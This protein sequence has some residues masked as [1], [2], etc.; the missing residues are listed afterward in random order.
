M[1]EEHGQ[2]KRRRIL[3]PDIAGSNLKLWLRSDL[4]I[5][6]VADPV[7]AAWT[8]AAGWSAAGGGVYSHAGGADNLSQAILV[9]GNAYRVTYT[10]SGV[11]GGTIQP[12]AGT[13]AG[14]SR[15]ADGTYTEVL[16]CAGN[17]SMIFVGTGT[18]SVGAIS[19]ESMSC[20][21][22]ADQ[23]ATGASFT[24][25]T[26]L[27]QPAYYK[28]GGAIDLPYLS[29]NGAH[30]LVGN[31]WTLL[32]NIS[33]VA[34][35]LIYVVDL[36]AGAFAAGRSGGV[37]RYY[38]SKY[39]WSY[40]TFNTLVYVPAN[41]LQVLHF[42]KSAGDMAILRDGSS[43]ATVAQALVALGADN[44][45]IGD[46]GGPAYMT[47]KLYEVMCFAPGLTA[48]QIAMLTEWTMARYGV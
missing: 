30:V 31:P 26:A 14:T 25:A 45:R 17:T 7:I 13:T 39:S 48:A 16:V 34:H 40:D 29:F 24:N 11:A 8:L 3:P 37:P 33:N 32:A 38:Q 46:C 36:P 10:V 18:A 43:I 12:Y 47:G 20:S 1:H 19:I 28:T 2:P 9:V 23:S 6:L 4:G 35:D 42:Q 5:T 44:L 21:G 41:G 22:W 15:A 27:T